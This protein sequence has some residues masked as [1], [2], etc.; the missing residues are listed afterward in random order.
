M[1][2]PAVVDRKAI[3]V[4]SPHAFVNVCF[5]CRKSFPLHPQTLSH[6]KKKFSFL[7]SYLALRVCM[8]V[9]HHLVTLQFFFFQTPPHAH[10]YISLLVFFISILWPV[11]FHNSNVPSHSLILIDVFICSLWCVS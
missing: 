7:C 5:V 4:F 9:C 2:A 10:P 3:Y 8:C 1:E 6:N 11:F